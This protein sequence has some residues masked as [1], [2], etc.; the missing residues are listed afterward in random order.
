MLDCDRAFVNILFNFIPHKTIINDDK[1]PSWFTKNIKS[2]IRE[3]NNVYKSH[4][5]S[6]NNNN[7]R[8]LRKLKFLQE[9]LH[10][11]IEVFKLN[12]H[13]R[14]TNKLNHT[15]KSSEAYLALLTKFLNNKKISLIQP[16]FH[17]HEY[18]TD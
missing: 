13:S 8:F 7:I 18:L 6:E 3:K 2:L 15:H 9:R 14:I 5:N 1:D 17:R 11:E 4:R 10:N 16:L 12:Y